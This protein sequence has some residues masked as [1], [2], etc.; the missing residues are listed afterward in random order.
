MARGEILMK[1]G[2]VKVVKSIMLSTRN[3]NRREVSRVAS[4]THKGSETERERRAT[5]F[6]VLHEARRGAFYLQ[7]RYIRQVCYGTTGELKR[8]KRNT[9]RVK[10]SKLSCSNH[11]PPSRR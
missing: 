5:V 8:E 7:E 3:Q 2:V 11:C 10:E 9:N 1:A 6:P 4:K